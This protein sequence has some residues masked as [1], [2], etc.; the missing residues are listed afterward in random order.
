MNYH[1]P[2]SLFCARAQ[3]VVSI[4][5]KS[6]I[7]KLCTFDT[8]FKVYRFLKSSPSKFCQKIL[9]FLFWREKCVFVTH[10]FSFFAPNYYGRSQIPKKLSALEEDDAGFLAVFELKLAFLNTVARVQLNLLT[11]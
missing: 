4:P 2:L 3:K 9:G 11:A 7:F 6:A 1:S 8:N 5:K 10:F